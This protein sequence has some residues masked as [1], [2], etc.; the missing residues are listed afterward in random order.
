MEEARNLT[1]I[2]SAT[3]APGSTKASAIGKNNSKQPLVNKEIAA[4]NHLAGFSI[5]LA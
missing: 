1:S 4:H 3:V 5:S 2:C